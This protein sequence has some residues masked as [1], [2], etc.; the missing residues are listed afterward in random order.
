MTD[1]NLTAKSRRVLR[2]E[3]VLRQIIGEHLISI[4]FL[5]N[6]VMVTVIKVACAS[7]LR[8]AS[9]YI[10]VYH[11][12]GDFDTESVFDVLEG[13]RALIQHRIGKELPIKFC[14]R[15]KFILDS[16]IDKMTHF[17][18]LLHESRA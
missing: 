15:L 13:Q 17:S 18:Q 12:N 9:V 4:S 16:S 8:S 6:A 1:D 5:F 11:S 14:P 10:S 2:V 7:D 3:K